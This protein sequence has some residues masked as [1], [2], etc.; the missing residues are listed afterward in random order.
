VIGK[1]V[2]MM[3]DMRKEESQ[4]EKCHVTSNRSEYDF[5]G[6]AADKRLQ[7]L[8]LIKSKH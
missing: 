4:T 8:L 7:C 1:V 5:S 2:V 3:L 6:A